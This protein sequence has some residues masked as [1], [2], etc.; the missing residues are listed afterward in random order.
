M[1]SL[2]Y[3]KKL[4]IIQVSLYTVL[5]FPVV[6]SDCLEGYT[7]GKYE[8][9]TEFMADRTFYGLKKQL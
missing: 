9:L 4:G 2:E 7:L 5:Y 3:V 1:A 8:L 6:S